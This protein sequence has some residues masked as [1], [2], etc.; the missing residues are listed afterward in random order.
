MST[1]RTT[2]IA[3]ATSFTAVASLQSLIIPVLSTI[4]TDIGADAVGQTW[5]LTA[6]LISAA[7]ATPLLGAAKSIWLDVVEGDDHA[8]STPS[9]RSA[10]SKPSLVSRFRRTVSPKT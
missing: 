3:V 6:W 7:V 4:G 5:M 10:G 1:T 8:P 2:F 9:K